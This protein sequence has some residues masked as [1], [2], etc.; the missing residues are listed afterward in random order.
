MSR[1]ILRLVEP[2]AV[3]VYFDGTRVDALGKKE[4]KP[5]RRRM[6]M[7]FQDPYGSLNPRRKVSETLRQSIGIHGLAKG[8]SEEDALIEIF[9]TP[10]ALKQHNKSVVPYSGIFHKQMGVRERR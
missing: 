1:T 5:Y 6:Q 10:D 2:T 9:S 8:R 7:I 3:K 4:F